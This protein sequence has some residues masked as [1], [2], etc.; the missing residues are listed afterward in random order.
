MASS[1]GVFCNAGY[2]TAAE[3]L[4]LGKKMLVIKMKTQYGQACYAE[5]LKSMGVT[6]IKNLKKK[7]YEKISGWLSEGKPIHVEYP[8]ETAELLDL[9]I[10]RHAGKAMDSN[11]SS[12]GLDIFN[13]KLVNSGKFAASF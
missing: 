5:V 2:G 13:K 1:N 3:A 6:L 11:S 7:N 10:T 8:D 12:F 4:Y 9:I